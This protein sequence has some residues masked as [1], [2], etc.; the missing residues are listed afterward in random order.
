M[1]K[2]FWRI[3]CLLLAAFIVAP[4]QAQV[5]DDSEDGP[6]LPRFVSFRSD[7]INGRSGP[8]SRYPIEWVYT[9]KGA[10]VEVV[11]EFELW[12]KV[13]DW[14][15]SESWIHK[16]MLSNKRTAKV[17]TPGENN[18]YAEPDYKSKVIARAEDETVAEIVKCPAE[19]G[20]CLLKFGQISGWMSKNNLYGVYKEEVI[21]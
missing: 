20:F 6:N 15:G 7:H 8:G 12:R 11:A 19:H 21:D 9:Q 14:Q 16:S 3:S 4:V 1:S 2:L 18:L 5:I 17:I 10:P 13:K